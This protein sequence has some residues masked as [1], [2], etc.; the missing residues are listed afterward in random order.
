MTTTVNTASFEPSFALGTSVYAA[1]GD[2]T[3]FLLFAGK[4]LVRFAPPATPI[5]N[6][7]LRAA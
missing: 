3:Y 7:E 4:H 1:A 2:A 5:K 6:T